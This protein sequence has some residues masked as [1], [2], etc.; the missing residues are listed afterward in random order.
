MSSGVEVRLV[1][2]PLGEAARSGRDGPPEARLPE[3]E[4]AG[5]PIRRF[6]DAIVGGVSGGA[7]EEKIVESAF[8]LL[9]IAQLCPGQER[10]ESRPFG[11]RQVP[12]L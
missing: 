8:V 11:S 3:C 1:L 5:C 4:K 6:P 7:L 12:S 9:R 2:G 10:T